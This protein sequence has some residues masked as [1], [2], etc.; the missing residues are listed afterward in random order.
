MKILMWWLTFNEVFF[1]CVLVILFGVPLRL[2]GV[3]VKRHVGDYIF[4]VADRCVKFDLMTKDEAKEL[5]R[6]F[7]Q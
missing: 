5:V 2:I 4:G 7:Y 3:D 6:H 1:M